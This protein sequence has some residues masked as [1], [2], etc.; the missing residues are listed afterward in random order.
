MALVFLVRKA[1]T[2]FLSLIVLVCV[3]ACSSLLFFPSKTLV[4][5]PEDVGVAYRDI[6]FNAADGIKLHGWFLPAK[7]EP[8]GS[9]LFLHGNAENISTHLYSVYWLPSKGFNVFLY[10]YRGYGLSNGEPELA[11]IVL[12]L[13]TAYETLLDQ[14]EVDPDKVVLFGQSLGGA[15]GAYGAVTAIGPERIRALVVES[16]FAS[17][18]KIAREKLD[19]FFLTWPLQWPL[20][21]L[22]DDGYSPVNVISQ[23]HPTPLLVI[24][25]A[26]D[27]IVP[28]HHGV[29]LFDAALQPK[30]MW[31]VSHGGHISAFGFEEYRTRFVEYLTYLLNP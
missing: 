22:V 3:S 10:D 29:A 30:Q 5:V 31:I 20:S 4:R 25:G 14:P 8:K 13:K 26:K 23:L 2:V 21:L 15:I 27:N 28:L 18:R 1:I 9:I 12:D 19:S 6:D 11:D 16:A 17:Y 24:H 7:G